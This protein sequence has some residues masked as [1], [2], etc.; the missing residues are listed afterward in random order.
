MNGN[1]IN[2]TMQCQIGIPYR[3]IYKMHNKLLARTIY[4]TN[5]IDNQPSG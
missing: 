3:I 5:D 4:L 1:N 2:A